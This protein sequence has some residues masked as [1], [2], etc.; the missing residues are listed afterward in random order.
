MGNNVLTKISEELY[1]ISEPEYQETQNNPFSANVCTMAMKD[2]TQIKGKK[3]L[4]SMENTAN[5]IQLTNAQ[6]YTEL[7]PGRRILI[8]KED[9]PIQMSLQTNSSLFTNN[10]KNDTI[11]LKEN[12]C[13]DKESIIEK[14]KLI[15]LLSEAN[16]KLQ[17]NTREISHLK[18]E[19]NDKEVDIE[20]MKEYSENVNNILK[21]EIYKRKVVLKMFKYGFIPYLIYLV[22]SLT[23]MVSSATLF[24]AWRFVGVLTFNPG[25]LFMFTIISLG[26]SATAIAGLISVKNRSKIYGN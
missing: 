1:N 7:K 24:L 14:Q 26:W 8:I 16:I 19:I 5:E 10:C 13:S 22:I 9:A 23:I 17:A 12:N 21:N 11:N 25:A 3:I 18:K 2:I 15:E 4:Y 6:F 20:E